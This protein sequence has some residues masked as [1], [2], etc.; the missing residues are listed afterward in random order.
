MQLFLSTK[1]EGESK[2]QGKRV[3]NRPYRVDYQR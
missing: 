1:G 3:K 2:T